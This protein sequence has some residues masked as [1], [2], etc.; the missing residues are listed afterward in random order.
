M[1]D[2]RSIRKDYQVAALDRSDLPDDPLVLFGRWFDEAHA[3]GIDEPNG[4]ALATVEPDG[5][6]ACRT[7]LMRSID[8]RGLA[9]FTN[10]ESPKARALRHEPRAAGT[11][12]WGPL[13]RQIR[14]EGVI[15]AVPDTEADEYWATRPRPSQLASW[16]SP[17]SEEIPDRAWL[18]ARIAAT[19]QIHP[20]GSAVPRPP[21]WG[22]FRIVIDTFEFWQGRGA[23]THDRFRYTRRP[24][25]AFEISRLAP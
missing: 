23:R 4:M 1:T 18:E 10:R 15:E 25:G 16:S 3:A 24:D 17:Q 20:E 2:P 5:R 19:A 22:G 11:F 8:A 13:E 7:M 6:P 14:I 12:W 21:F 9:F